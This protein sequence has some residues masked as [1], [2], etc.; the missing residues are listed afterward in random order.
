MIFITWRNEMLKV[1]GFDSLTRRAS[2]QTLD[3]VLTAA[4]DEELAAY[5]AGRAKMNP[6]KVWDGYFKPMLEAMDK[7][8]RDEVMSNMANY[9]NQLATSEAVG[10]TEASGLTFGGENSDE[11]EDEEKNPDGSTGK[12]KSHPTGDAMRQWRGRDHD[13]IAN[14]QKANESFWKK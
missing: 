7:V 8:I 14:M 9:G 10:E 13:R 2:Q 6:G 5:M 11:K 12:G 1:R 4:T 3:T